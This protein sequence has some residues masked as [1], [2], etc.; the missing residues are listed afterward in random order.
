MPWH[1]LAALP[2]ALIALA[3]IVDATLAALRAW[4]TLITERLAR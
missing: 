2:V 3:A 1:L 4:R